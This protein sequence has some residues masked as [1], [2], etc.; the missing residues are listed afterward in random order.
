MRRAIRS[1]VTVRRSPLPPPT[2]DR[3]LAGPTL[4]D[5]DG[6]QAVAR[7]S[8][9]EGGGDRPVFHEGMIGLKADG[10]VFFPDLPSGTDLAEGLDTTLALLPVPKLLQ[11][12]GM[13]V[14]GFALG[15]ETRSA[16]D[17]LA[18]PRTAFV[19]FLD[20][21]EVAVVRLG[22]LGRGPCLVQ[23]RCQDQAGTARSYSFGGVG[24]RGDAAGADLL[25]SVLV[26]GRVRCDLAGIEEV[27]RARELDPYLHVA[28]GMLAAA[29]PRPVF[30][31]A[32]TAQARELWRAALEQEGRS[33]WD[34]VADRMRALLAD[35]LPDYR[36][37]PDIE[38]LV[39]DHGALLA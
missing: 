18:D 17:F 19:P 34:A 39:G 7:A 13:A 31:G 27:A 14:H 32:V 20:V 9:A 33:P 6:R 16:A 38:R 23:V 36:R 2:P 11:L 8:L 1:R 35:V 4:S 15:R 26:E 30:D 24:G 12:A 3:I 21:V 10:L 37:I 28:A 5:V 25:A 22:V 29:G